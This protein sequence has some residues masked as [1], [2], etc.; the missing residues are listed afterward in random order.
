MSEKRNSL[1]KSRD[2][3]EIQLHQN[4][5]RKK[6]FSSLFPEKQKVHIVVKD[7]SASYCL[8]FLNEEKIHSVPVVDRSQDYHILGFVDMMDICAFV[9]NIYYSRTLN[10]GT[11][12]I[13]FKYIIDRDFQKHKASELIDLSDN[14]HLKLLK[15]DSA[16][17]YDV[18]SV[19]SKQ[20]YGRVVLLGSKGLFESDNKRSLERIVTRADI[21]KFVKQNANYYHF[22][23]LLN[24]PVSF[25]IEGQSEITMANDNT[26]CIDAFRLM[27]AKK[28]HALPIVN[29]DG[30]LVGNLSVRD[31]EA[32]FNDKNAVLSSPVGEYLEKVLK[33]N[34]K[35]PE[36]VISTT[37]EDSI[38]HAIELMI[39]NHIHRVWV[40]DTN[41]H[42]I[43]VIS[44]SDI[45]RIFAMSHKE[46]SSSTSGGLSPRSPRRFSA[47]K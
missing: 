25:A 28:I 5:V 46:L 20:G 26:P 42:P 47:T 21:L 14:N 36:K 18:L 10:E 11:D 32:S 16:T 30:V 8:R 37:K 17:F 45:C 23:D 19:L 35:A 38:Q 3:P 31:V 39:D 13:N 29:D 4:D 27:V 12:M 34:P 33:T 40:V 2:K 43:G 1:D 24:M 15:W 7:T 44:A 6:K 22:H 41:N 9:T